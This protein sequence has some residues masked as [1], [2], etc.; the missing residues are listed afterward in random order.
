MDTPLRQVWDRGEPALNGWLNI[1]HTFSAEIMAAQSFDALT[2]DCQHGPID[3]A[4]LLP[5]FQ[6]LKASGKTLMARVPWRD[7]VWIMKFLDAGAMGIIC[8]MVNTAEEAEEFVS[9]LRYPPHGQRSWGPTRAMFAYPGYN[10]DGANSAVLAFAMIETGTALENLEDIAST[11][12][13]DALYVGP[14]D[15]SVGMS[16]GALQPG[17]DREE[18]EVIE[19]IQRIVSVAHDRGIRAALH[20]ASPEYAAR[21]IGWGYDMV[22][23]GTDS[24][25]LAQGAAQVTKAFR[26]LLD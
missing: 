19:A 2:I 16:N 4:A 8:P 5:M 23:I 14:S 25:I 10:K 11:P 24:V 21:A 12:H 18:P 17:M 3:Y 9:Y 1:G 13:L 6:A 22:T 26:S 20:C 7:P 15:L